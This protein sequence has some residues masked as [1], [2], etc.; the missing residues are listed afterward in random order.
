MP[1]DLIGTGSE[2][3]SHA[4]QLGVAAEYGAQNPGSKG[5]TGSLRIE[6]AIAIEI[7]AGDVGAS[8]AGSIA[9]RI[10]RP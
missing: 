2:L 7:A 9:L 1:T 10:S 8:V 6:I 3:S 5:K 4:P